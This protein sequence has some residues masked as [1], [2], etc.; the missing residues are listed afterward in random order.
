MI[1]QFLY[2][3]SIKIDI[4]YPDNQ[5]NFLNY[6]QESLLTKKKKGYVML[7]VIY[8]MRSLLQLR[9]FL[10]SPRSPSN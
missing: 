7:E 8:C 4:R 3:H 5:H 2:Q 10:C 9:L 6:F 1:S